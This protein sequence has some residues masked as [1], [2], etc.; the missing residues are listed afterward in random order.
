MTRSTSYYT[1]SY[2]Y[3][4]CCESNSMMV[5][6]RELIHKSDIPKILKLFDFDY[7]KWT[8]K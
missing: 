1:I 6:Y 8:L 5:M 4:I 2:M 3:I 7:G